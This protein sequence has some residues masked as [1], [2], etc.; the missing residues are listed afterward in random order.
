MNS[1]LVLVQIRSLETQLAV[2][3]TRLK[4]ETNGRKP[5]AAYY[6]VLAGK[7]ETSETELQ[8]SELKLDSHLD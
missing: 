4:Q 1:N 3:R 8:A 7:A 5:F 2:L 6:G